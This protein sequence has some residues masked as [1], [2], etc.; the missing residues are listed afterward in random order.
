MA[1]M[2]MVVVAVV[3]VGPVLV[4]VMVVSVFVPLTNKSEL[5]TLS[6]S[7]SQAPFLDDPPSYPAA[8]GS[9]GL[10]APPSSS[11]SSA[12]PRTPHND[13]I[14]PALPPL[15][16]LL[17]PQNPKPAA[18]IACDG[19][20]AAAAADARPLAAGAS[21]AS[22]RRSRPAPHPASDVERRIP[23]IFL[24]LLYGKAMVSCQ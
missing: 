6:I 12:P 9:T 5:C 23:A 22:S 20:N 10:D 18:L 24:A 16:L 2:V 19:P 11:F 13:R 8:A 7:F 1:A 3:A 17:W 21:A 4:V 14:A 15:L